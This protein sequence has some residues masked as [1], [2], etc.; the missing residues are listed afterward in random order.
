MILGIRET[1]LRVRE[2]PLGSGK[3][4]RVLEAAAYDAER[5]ILQETF[6]EL[7]I[8]GLYTRA[9]SNQERVIMERVR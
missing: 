6:L 1:P 3:P 4:P 5:F 2:T 7:K 8:C 9:A